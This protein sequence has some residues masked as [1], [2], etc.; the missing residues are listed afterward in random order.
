V[1]SRRAEIEAVLKHR[2]GA[3]ALVGEPQA[4]ARED[5]ARPWMLDA[6]ADRQCL[7]AQALRVLETAV[8]KRAARLPPPGE[9]ARD[10]LAQLFGE[11]FRRGD[12]AVDGLHVAECQVDALAVLAA[13][14]LPLL[15]ARL[16]GDREQL[17]CDLQAIG[18]VVRSEERPATRGER[19]SST[20]SCRRSG[21]RA[22]ATRR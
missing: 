4:L 6:L 15:V 18:D 2:F 20:S 5:R 10:R 21:A 16:L 11:P 12:L 14:E 3:P 8:A 17:G 9:P 13:D 1:D 19:L 22:P 7:V